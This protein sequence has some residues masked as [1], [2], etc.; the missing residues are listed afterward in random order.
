MLTKLSV[1][2]IPNVRSVFFGIFVITLRGK[3]KR[4]SL[5]EKCNDANNM[6]DSNKFALVLNT[7]QKKSKNTN[8]WNVRVILDISIR[9]YA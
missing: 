5:F 4:D 6:Y 9:H 8:A 7:E 1:M 3:Q 2:L